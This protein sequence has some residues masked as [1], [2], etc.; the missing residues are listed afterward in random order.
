MK[1]EQN[2][3]N[4]VNNIE[5]ENEKTLKCY[6]CNIVKPYSA[7]H[8]QKKC[9]L[10]IWLYCKDC[11]KERRRKWYHKTQKTPEKRLKQREQSRL[12]RE[13]QKLKVI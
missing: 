1:K 7:Y 12:Y 6:R 5:I 11:D 4:G 13:K 8:K 10:G 3:E 2:K 9:K